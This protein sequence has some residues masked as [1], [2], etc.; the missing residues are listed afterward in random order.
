VIEAV[1]FDLDDTL[2]PQANWLDGAWCAVALAAPATVDRVALHHA[3]VALASEGSDK[4]HIIDRALVA[5]GAAHIDPAPLVVAFRA[6]APARLDA[7][8]HAEEAISAVRAHVPVALVSDGEVQGQEAKL[9]ALG[10]EGAFDAIVWSDALGRE[11]RKPHPAPFRA[12]IDRLGARAEACIMIG[13]RPD[14]D[15]RGARAAGLLGSIRVR[16]GEYAF[17]P[18]EQGCLATVE[19]LR[20]ATS[21]VCALLDGQPGECSGHR[22]S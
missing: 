16:T 11:F 4:G 20:E 17:Q 14:K 21:H 9:R 1:L 10:L 5:T 15:T 19:D 18:D 8:P 3:L 12:A 7:Y 6:H 2:Y 22:G 13:D